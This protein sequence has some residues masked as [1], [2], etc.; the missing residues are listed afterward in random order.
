LRAKNRRRGAGKLGCTAARIAARWL[1]QRSMEFDMSTKPS[2]SILDRSFIYVPSTATSVD[3]TW[4]RFGWRPSTESE[5]THE[6]HPRPAQSAEAP[7][8]RQ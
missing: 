1:Q 5:N 7:P 3:Q 8:A 2:K 4:R 6:T